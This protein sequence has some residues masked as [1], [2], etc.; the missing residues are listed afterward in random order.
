LAKPEVFE[1]LCRESGRIEWVVYAK[2]PFGGP[3]QVLKYLARYTHRVAI[4]NSR[5]LSIEG[6]R[7]TF[8]WKDLGMHFTHGSVIRLRFSR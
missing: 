8:K 6:G 2:L 4:S 1:A 3:E 7:V 5:L